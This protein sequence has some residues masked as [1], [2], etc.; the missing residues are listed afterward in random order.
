M[1]KLLVRTLDGETF[2]LHVESGHTVGHL[3][4]DA[5]RA[6]GNT[7]ACRLKLLHNSALLEPSTPV[8][9]LLGETLDAV[10]YDGPM[11][12]SCSLDDRAVRVWD[13]QAMECVGVLRGHTA[14][15]HDVHAHFGHMQALSGSEDNTVRHWD[16]RTLTCTAVLRGHSYP[17]NVVVADFEA[18]SG[19]SGGDD[20]QIRVWDLKSA[21]CLAVLDLTEGPA[22]P[23]GRWLNTDEAKAARTAADGCV[24]ALSVDFVARRAVSACVG[25]VFHVWDLAAGSCSGYLGVNT[26]S[27]SEADR[28]RKLGGGLAVVASF[29][30]ARAL[31]G[32]DHG[33]CLWD[34]DQQAC[35][36]RLALVGRMPS[37]IAVDF[38]LGV[39]VV[40]DFG[41]SL[42]LWNLG[43]LERFAEA[44]GE[45]LEDAVD[46]RDEEIRADW[47]EHFERVLRDGTERQDGWMGAFAADIGASRCLIG[48]E[49]GRVELWDLTGQ[50]CLDSLDGYAAAD[51]VPPSDDEEGDDSEDDGDTEKEPHTYGGK[52]ATISG[53]SAALDV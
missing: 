35:I 46:D 45:P 48:F 10:E 5:A 50:C 47:E 41:G 16:L 15:V 19:V 26:N 2:D 17:I 49:K 36:I 14:G 51:L 44:V 42:Y 39:A 4:V 1:D 38:E 33:A 37:H 20:C 27:K 21:E 24:L 40:G 11:F 28:F 52:F 31:T 43:Q 22:R 25:G 53:L 6:L 18:A 12:A 30:Q 8:D 29:S 34:L 13:A 23:P 7:P 3:L 32:S 9:P